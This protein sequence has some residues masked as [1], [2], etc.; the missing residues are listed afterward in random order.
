MGST[1]LSI[2]RENVKGRRY[3]CPYQFCGYV[4]IVPAHFEGE[5]V[6]PRCLYE[7]QLDNLKTTPLKDY[8]K[9]FRWLF[10]GVGAVLAGIALT[11]AALRWWPA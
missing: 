6:C 10:I 11:V 5:P 3:V 1:T 7:G 2:P 4:H 8:L 9:E